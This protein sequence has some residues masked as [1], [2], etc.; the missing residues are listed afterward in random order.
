MS[1]RVSLVAYTEPRAVQE[2]Q[3]MSAHL[4]VFIHGDLQ[5]FVFFLLT[6]RLGR[7]LGT[8]LSRYDIYSVSIVY[9]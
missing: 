1:F 5:R 8:E 4:H 3:A 2:G 6:V 7:G 9:L